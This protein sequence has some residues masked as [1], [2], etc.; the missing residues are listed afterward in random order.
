MKELHTFHLTDEPFEDYRIREF[1]SSPKDPYGNMGLH[2]S[3]AESKWAKTQSYVWRSGLRWL[4]AAYG[5]VHHH[6]TK[7]GFCHG[8]SSGLTE[9]NSCL[10]W[11]SWRIS[12]H[13]TSN[14]DMET[15]VAFLSHVPRLHA[16]VDAVTHLPLH[17]KK[18][19]QINQRKIHDINEV[20]S[21]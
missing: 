8:E 20:G 4:E 2:C 18:S 15:R 21:N 7:Q 3:W 16:H 11:A 19:V 9:R 10:H 12:S 17:P 14:R 5:M 13:T 6:L 1:L